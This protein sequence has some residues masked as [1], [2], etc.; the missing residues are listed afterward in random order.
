MRFVHKEWAASSISALFVLKTGLVKFSDE[1][2]V[3]L[4]GRLWRVSWRV[5]PEQELHAVTFQSKWWR[6]RW[7]RP[8]HRPSMCPT[9]CE[10]V[11]CHSLSC[12]FCAHLGF[13][14][15]LFKTTSF[16]RAKTLNEIDLLSFGH[17]WVFHEVHQKL[18]VAEV[19]FQLDRQSTKKSRPTTPRCVF[20]L[21]VVRSARTPFPW[22]L[23]S[24]L[25]GLHQTRTK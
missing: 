15:F 8:Q 10:I 12:F 17:I 6:T 13:G 11:L 23:T 24:S 25:I 14:N 7:D 1:L 22:K 18:G 20:Y 2:T 5:A 3:L 21:F 4:A 9:V 19:T 16:A